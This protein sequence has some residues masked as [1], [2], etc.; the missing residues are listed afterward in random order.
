V[1]TRINIRFG[2]ILLALYGFAT[3]GMAQTPS[4]SPSTLGQGDEAL[5]E[6]SLAGLL[7]TD[8]VL[9]TFTGPA[10]TSTLEPQVIVDG[11]LIVWVPV[12]TMNNAGTYSVY[13]DVTR[14]AATTRYGPAQ[15]T[16]SVLSGGTGSST[17]LTLPE[18]VT[19]EASSATGAI[20]TFSASSSDGSPV[21]CSPSSGSMF[22][23]GTSSV[24]CSAGDASGSFSAFVYDTGRPALTVPADISTSNPVVT[25][26]ATASDAID[27]APTVEC[28]PLSGSTF[29]FGTTVVSC[30]AVDQHANSDFGSFRVTI[31]N[32][33][34]V[35]I[36]NVTI[37]DP[38]F[39]P[40]AD[41]S[42]DATTVAANAPSVDTAWTVTVVSP[43]GATVRTASRSGAALSFTWDGRDQGGVVQ[44]DG[45]YT[46]ALKAVDG[47]H[48]ASVATSA[49]LDRT[50]PMA[51]ILSPSSG[52][53]LSNVRQSGSSNTTATG[54]T[55]DINLLDW[56][57]S[58]GPASGS[59]TVFGTGSTAVSNATLGA[60][61]TAGLANGTYM[62]RLEVRDRAGNTGFTTTTV[63]IAHFSASQS[64]YELNAASGQ[65]L[66]YTSVVPFTVTQ[67]LT[68][69]N[70]AGTTVRTLANG[71][72]AAGTYDDVWN[73][74]DDA[75]TLLPDG[76]YSYV[77]TVSEGTNSLTWDLS[78]VMRSAADTQ[79]PYPSC[80]AMQMPLD[81]CEAQALAGK[82]YDL[83]GNDPLKIH[84]SVAGPSRV[85]VVFTDA[86]E[87]PANCGAAETCVI[88]SEYRATGTY[89]DAW[90]GVHPAG[91]YAA[92]RSKLT[93]V[94]R[95]STFPENV[96][97]LFGSGAAVQVAN[98]TLTPPAFTP[99][100][101][102]MNI[103]LD[104]STFGNA[105]AT[106][107]FQMIRQPTTTLGMSTL[108][109]VTLNAQNPGHVTFTW[110]GKSDSGHWV[111][112]GEYA[113]IATATAN[114][115]SSQ[116]FSRFA[117][118]Y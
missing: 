80:S 118:I 49:V 73:G 109:T 43:S 115:R 30:T 113:L 18:V 38:F 74:R 103:E 78:N 99:E 16:V 52:Q 31:T 50:N 2:L 90:A 13:V 44:P 98:L 65:T 12:A 87:T 88:S 108:R 60:W 32:G 36:S 107:T 97:V 21:S 40:N 111:A 59:L 77:T 61:T 27:P 76:P 9:V 104:L 91:V 94:R 3:A 54:T 24:T 112:P 42:H 41:G 29:A 34:P 8:Y 53:I 7:A 25:Y 35:T 17:S 71:S 28:V 37:S 62:I 102:S 72:R 116:A 57:V 79:Y 4:V 26:S 14:D 39:S 33:A 1:S 19:A 95:T 63:T 101:G 86:T 68:I 5:V 84:Y 105:E 55:S 81:T 66:T 11:S 75:G 96:A 58:A 22:P 82:Q 48:E 45:T 117:V 67:T 110:D 64:A 10:G 20:V 70:S 15:L 106:V 89:V 56:N 83:F 85:S 47:I 92:P 100:A 46:F 69:R 23:L 51:A 6:I 114:G 93:V